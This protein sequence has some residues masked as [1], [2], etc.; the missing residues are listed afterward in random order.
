MPDMK[1]TRSTLSTALQT[2]KK[3]DGASRK[4][5]SHVGGPKAGTGLDGDRNKISNASASSETD[6]QGGS[7]GDPAARDKR[8][9]P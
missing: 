5:S 3:T 4:P 1:P 6:R 2:P 9:Q 8:G 7:I